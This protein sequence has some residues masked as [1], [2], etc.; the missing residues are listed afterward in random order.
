MPL[1]TADLQT[2]N[3]LAIL[4]AAKST[5]DPNGSIETQ[6]ADCRALA[7]QEG[8]EIV[9]EQSD[10]DASA[11]SGDRGP[12]LAAALKH[13]KEIGAVLIVQHSDRLARGDGKAARHLAELFFTASRAGITLRSCQDDSTFDSPILAAV[14]GERNSEDSKRKSA[15]VKAGLARRRASGRHTG[16]RPYG[17]SASVGNGRP[18]A[19]LQRPDSR[20][21]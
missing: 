8:F 7:E 11:W 19:A 1:S 20:P 10:E 5:K 17:I 16:T 15:S 9:A 6:L 12:E 21:G 4:Y 2:P 18:E 13:A 14:M 3:G